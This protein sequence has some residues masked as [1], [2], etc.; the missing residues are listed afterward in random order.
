MTEIALEQSLLKWI[1]KDR[2]VIRITGNTNRKRPSMLFSNQNHRFKNVKNNRCRVRAMRIENIGCPIR[3]NAGNRKVDHII[4]I[5]ITGN[6]FQVCCLFNNVTMQ[7]QSVSLSQRFTTFLNS[8][9]T[10]KNK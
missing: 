8:S 10:R 7:V 2:R 6:R 5:L 3:D 1:K 4:M 9:I